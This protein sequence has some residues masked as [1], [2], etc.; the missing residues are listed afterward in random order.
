MGGF[1]I[2]F[3]TKIINIFCRLNDDL[4]DF[5]ST[6]Y[7]RKLESKKVPTEE[8][9][10][11]LL[12]LTIEDHVHGCSKDAHAFLLS[13]AKSMLCKTQE[14]LRP[15]IISPTQQTQS[16]ALIQLQT[17]HTRPELSG[18][19]AYV[20]GEATLAADLVR[21]LN[22]ALPGESI[23]VATPRRIQRHAVKE[24]LKEQTGDVDMVNLFEKL[25]LGGASG[26]DLVSGKVTVDTVERLQGKL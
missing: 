12:D 17:H 4:S 8:T 3:I 16:L 26:N 23:F 15:P 14:F 20:R 18:M 9:A 10:M 24:A 22:R 13:L 5:V 2:I 19:E 21:W 25:N 7:S 11:R 6:I 1:A